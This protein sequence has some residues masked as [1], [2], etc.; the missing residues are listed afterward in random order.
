LTKLYLC[1]TLYGDTGAKAFAGALVNNRTLK[2]L[3]IGGFGEVAMNALARHLPS[4]KGLKELT[5][6]ALKGLTPQSVNSLLNALERNNEL[7]KLTIYNAFDTSP[8]DKKL[9]DEVRPKLMNQVALNRAGKRILRSESHVP[10][11]L[12]PLILERSCKNPDAL[13]YFLREKPDVL[14]NKAPVRASRKR[15]RGWLSGLFW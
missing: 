6:N 10:S 2:S 3:E 14:I 7:E 11:A 12:W 8:N 5:M 13:F 9:I 4:M 15:K 1:N